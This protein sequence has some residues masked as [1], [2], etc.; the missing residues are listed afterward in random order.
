MTSSPLTGQVRATDVRVGRTHLDVALSDGRSIQVPIAWF[1]R[2]AGAPPH[3]LRR[4]RLIGRGIG[5]R[6]DEL[7]EDLSVEGLLRS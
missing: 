4:W 2:L 1:P 6:W 3:K 5:M 7:D